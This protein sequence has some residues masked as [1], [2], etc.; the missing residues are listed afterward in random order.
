MAIMAEE[1][2]LPTV[3]PAMD[4]FAVGGSSLIAAKAAHRLREELGLPVTVIDLF[5]APT[6]GHF[7]AVLGIEPEDARSAEVTRDAYRP[8]F[9]IRNRGEGT[10]LFCVH[11]SLGLSWCYASL[12]PHLPKSMPIYG[13]QARGA[14]GTGAPPSTL[15]AMADDYLRLLRD[16]QPTGPYQLLGWSFGGVVAQAMAVRLVAA[17]HEVPVLVVL[18][19]YAPSENGYPDLY[20]PTEEELMVDIK[21]TF[22]AVG[23]L[24]AMDPVDLR[25]VAVVMQNNIKLVMEHTPTPYPGDMIYVRA[26]DNLI[27]DPTDPGHWGR[28]VQ[29]SIDIHNVAQDHFHLL[30][31]D[32]AAIVAALLRDAS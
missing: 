13:F 19:A 3:T 9:P 28:F 4:F 21:E 31:P 22:G 12:L 27:T 16:I 24:D 2:R 15:E 18:D 25:R 29:G 1:L 23:A 5:D 30:Q 11:P 6:F 32:G 20:V 17:G 14:D 26:S 8:V 7:L 10:P